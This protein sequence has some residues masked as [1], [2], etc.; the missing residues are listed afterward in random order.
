M[1]NRT[2]DVFRTPSRRNQPSMSEIMRHDNVSPLKSRSENVIHT[3]MPVVTPKPKSTIGELFQ[4]ETPSKTGQRTSKTLPRTSSNVEANLVAAPVPA[5]VADT[6]SLKSQKENLQSD[7]SVYKYELEKE[8]RANLEANE[9]LNKLTKTKAALELDLQVKE[10]ALLKLEKEAKAEKNSFTATLRTQQETESLLRAQLAKETERRKKLEEE[11]AHR[12]RLYRDIT[13]EHM[14]EHGDNEALK[15][16]LMDAHLILSSQTKILEETEKAKQRR[17]L[18]FH[19]EQK[20]RLQLEEEIEELESE[21]SQLQF[22]Y[23]TAITSAEKEIESLKEKNGGLNIQLDL[24]SKQLYEERQ[25][26]EVQEAAIKQIK[27]DN[28]FLQK[29]IEELQS[30]LVIVRKAFK[31]LEQKSEIDLKANERQLQMTIEQ[32]EI[33]RAA[34]YQATFYLTQSNAAVTSE[35]KFKAEAEEK[36]ALEQKVTSELEEALKSERTE[37]IPLMQQQIAENNTRLSQLEKQLKLAQQHAERSEQELLAE[38][39][40][41]IATSEALNVERDQKK[42]TEKLL[43]EV[44]DKAEK[45]VKKEKMARL[46]V[47]QDLSVQLTLNKNS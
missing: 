2:D 44:Q 32:L 6:P 18:G 14:Q 37:V 36:L 42:S 43:V 12:D 23:D 26:A 39:K 22:K 13:F 46:K 27:S 7:A 25:K 40:L 31:I 10:D 30:Q 24:T 5:P 20:V 9:K 15:Q 47:E 38:R 1:S 34:E 45:E 41:R 28:L 16:K 8:R 33:L 4:D 17:S 29:T 19:E 3:P 21:L 11:V 35:K